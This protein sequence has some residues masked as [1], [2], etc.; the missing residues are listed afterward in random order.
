MKFKASLLALAV[1]FGTM[2]ASP[3]ALISV[4]DWTG[5]SDNSQGTITD[6]TV[7]GSDIDLATGGPLESISDGVYDPTVSIS[8]MAAYSYLT[9]TQV[10]TNSAG[11]T[12]PVPLI[13]FDLGADTVISGY[14]IWNYRDGSNDA[15]MLDAFSLCFATSAEGASGFGTSISDINSNASAAN[16]DGPQSITEIT[17]RYIEFSLLSRHDGKR[18]GVEE[19]QFDLSAVPEPSAALLSGLGLLALISGRRRM[20]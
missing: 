11:P 10:A 3:G 12:N 18:V 15:H 8:Q 1:A 14:Q 7:G 5:D 6:T 19:I 9:N 4:L 13:V 20:R 16:T 17:A 2:S